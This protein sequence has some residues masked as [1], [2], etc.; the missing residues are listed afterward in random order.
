VRPGD[1]FFALRGARHDGCDFLAAAAEAGAVAALVD[2][3][4]PLPAAPLPVIAVPRLALRMSAIAGRFHGEPSRALRVTGVTGTNGKTT[5]SQL[6]AQLF[7]A[8][9]APA[10][11]I[12]TLGAGLAGSIRDTGFTTPD[13]LDTQ[14]L[15]A[16]LRAA[17]ARRIAM[18]VSSH[19]L[20]QGRVA[21]IRFHTAVFTNLSRDHLD[22]HPDMDAYRDA[23]AQLFRQPG[24]EVAVINTDDPAGARIAA[25]LP[26]SVRRLDYSARGAG[27]ELRVLQSAFGPAGIRAR[28]ATPWGVGELVSP[29]LGQFN[30]ANL[31]AVIGAAC[32]QGFALAEVL[33]AVPGLR[34]APGR[35]QEIGAGPRVVV[36]YAHSPDALE[37]VLGALRPATA[38]RLWCVFGCGGDRD[39][40]KR[41]LMG[42]VAARG[43]DRLGLTS[44]NPRSEDP[45]AI[46][47]QILDGI[48]VPRRPD[49][50]LLLDR[51]AAIAHAI[52]AA[53]A[54]DTVLIAGK[55]H[56]A[57]QEVAGV[58]WPFD[59]AAAARAALAAREQTP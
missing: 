44:D 45:A 30:L 25:E 18:E 20:A 36:D 16:E 29:L 13:A 12:G 51:R 57:W 8:L 11:V 50:E 5:C 31:L 9:E 1:L 4:S 55:G 48:P 24:L 38:G 22:Y 43:A 14:R 41:P 19:S 17:G 46:A 35:M 42:A 7:T 40:G 54:E 49:T 47:A 53:A 37:Q 6:L 10:G 28:I 21:A 32:G 15:L 33:A 3:E 34:A 59:D 2:A 52:A 58:R 27:G 26:A 23:K 39:R 56:E